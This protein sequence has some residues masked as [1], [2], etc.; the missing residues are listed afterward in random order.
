MASRLIGRFGGFEKDIASL[1]KQVRTAMLRAGDTLQADM[2]SCL[3]EHITADVY[4]AYE[5]E[6]YV[7]R[8]DN[9]GLID[10]RKNTSTSLQPQEIGGSVVIQINYEPNGDSDGDGNR[11]DSHVDGDDLIGRIEKRDPDYNWNRVRSP[12][13]RPFFRNFVEEMIEGHRAENTLVSAMN[14]ADPSLGAVAGD[15]LV[16]E[17]EDWR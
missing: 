12:G 3:S 13:D 4:E 1:E 17:N 5:P 14:A 8:E 7:R 2:K 16:R 11:T 15:G 9:G 6:A 10:M